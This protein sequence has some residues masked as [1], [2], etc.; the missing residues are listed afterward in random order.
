MPQQQ[1][2][3]AILDWLVLGGYFALLLGIGA[4]ASRRE[5]TSG[6]FFLGGRRMPVWAVAASVLATA[7]TAAT[8]LGAPESAYVGNLTYLSATIGAVLGV[9]VVA[10]LFIP[11]FYR[12]NV[13][14]VYDLLERRLG[15]GGKQAASWMFMVGRIFASGSRVFIGA[16][17]LALI[18]F[19]N[20]GPAEQRQAMIAAIGVL[21]VLGVFTAIGGGIKTVIWTDVLQVTVMITAAIAALVFLLRAIPLDAAGIVRVLSET[22][23]EGRSKL[24]I[25]DPGLDLSRPRLGFNANAPFTLLTAITGFALLNIA[26]FG[27]DHDLTQ[28]MLTCRN[29]VKG[30]SSALLAMAVNLPITFVFMAIGL[31]LYI[32][33]QRPDIMGATAGVA[34][35]SGK[36]FLRFILDATPPGLTGLMLA[37]LFA[38]GVGSLNSV[39]AAL[40]AAFVND[41]YKPMCPGRE[42]GHYVRAGRFAIIGWAA[43]LG[44]FAVLCVFWYDPANDT[45]LTFVLGSMTFAYAGLLGV[46]LT[47]LLTPRGNTASAIA[48][49]L[50]GFLAVLVLQPAV[51]RWLG[52]YTGIEMPWQLKMA[53][54]WRLVLASVI[55]FAVCAAGRPRELARG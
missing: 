54:P 23:V 48:A 42:D 26:A 11:A 2:G 9:V 32:Y 15:R 21:M 27:T 37:G 47:V 1:S 22:Q 13:T 28:R 45:I 43:I 25:I 34:P 5:K 29:A 6:E 36:V 31:L 19:P 55:A 51:W 24:T 7:T 50:I 33:Y 16:L 30:G 39:L 35:E 40:S 4:W 3:F 53:F 14:T 8:F 12:A 10:L 41:V 20:A 49:L 46:F 44:A 17:P 18:L 38:V 52:T